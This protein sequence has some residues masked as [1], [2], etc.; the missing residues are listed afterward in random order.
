MYRIDPKRTD[1]AEEFKANPFGHHSP[2]LQL[3][4]NQMRME[5]VKGRY[6]LV[7]TGP[8]SYTLAQLSGE[9]GV[10]PTLL[11]EHTFDDPDAAEWA[12]FK[13]RWKNLTGAELNID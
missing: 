7:E 4:L 6:V 3:V 13:L 1:L 5:R 2:E 8:R 12:A 10:A 11:P 9:R